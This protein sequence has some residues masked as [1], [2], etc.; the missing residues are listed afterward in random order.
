M[1]KS[2]F[3]QKISELTDE[4]FAQVERDVASARAARG[5]G[6]NDPDFRK[7]VAN[8]SDRDLDKMFD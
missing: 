2:D 3:E 5:H 4:Q 1:A 7:K 8:M 6:G